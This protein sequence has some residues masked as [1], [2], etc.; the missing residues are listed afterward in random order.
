[1]KF[2]ALKLGDIFEFALGPLMRNEPT[3]ETDQQE[4]LF[5]LVKNLHPMG[6]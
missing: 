6:Y 2:T 4:K 5:S 1:M 3:S